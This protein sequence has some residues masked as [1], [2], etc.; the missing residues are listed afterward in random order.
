MKKILIPLICLF[1]L[2]GTG[3]WLLVRRSPVEI[4]LTETP[5]AFRIE[6]FGPGLVI[7]YADGQTP[8]RAM[9]WLAPVQGG[10]QPVQVVTQS[11][12]QRL[13]LFQNATMVSNLLVPRPVGV[14]EGFFNFA[15]LHAAVVVPG[16][17]AVLLYRSADA[18]TGELPLVVAMDLST[19]AMRWVHRA[20]G[21]HLA[22]GGDSQEAA[23]FLYG[24]D[25]PVLRLPLALRKQEQLGSTPFRAAAKPI[26]LPNEIKGVCDLLPTDAWSFLVAHTGGLSS[27]SENKGWKH[28]QPLSVA[29][30]TFVDAKP[31][32]V[33][34]GKTY[35]WQP[36][37]GV[38]TQVKTDGTPIAT[39]D[40][41]ALAPHEPWAKDAALLSLRGV[42][43]A[44]NLWFTLA[45]P[46]EASS[47]AT[48]AETAEAS[49][50]RAESR[51][52]SEAAPTPETPVAE[53]PPIANGSWTTYA[54]E[55]LDRLYRW[56]P[57]RRILTGITQA[58]FWAALALPPGVNR[59]T[60]FPAFDPASGHLLL[61]SGPTAWLVPLEALPFKPTGSAGKAQA[62]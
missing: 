2:L 28:W 29:T 41:A 50:G 24:S 13:L 19:Q 22:L 14:R 61:E 53:P 30:L 17:V 49:P 8:L 27:Y 11:D 33:G 39:Y 62:R 51:D 23:V 47:V 16:D 26:A 54:A 10:I 31:A 42:D 59:T 44:G 12:R 56:N 40:A 58:D 5:A 21:E 43:P 37:P 46:S 4:P 55:G 18:S 3:L 45:I 6:P 34:S 9:R 15:E 48:P 36:F 52:H 60:G 57:E 35:W 1:G 7:H 38:V 32:V 25:S 20:P